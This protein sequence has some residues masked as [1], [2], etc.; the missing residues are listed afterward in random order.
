VLVGAGVLE[1]PDAAAEQR[2]HQVDVHLVDQP[3]GQ[4]LAAR[5][6]AH[7][8]HIAV[9]GGRRR[10]PQRRFRPSVM[11]AKVP[12]FT[13]S[14][15]SSLSSGPA[16]NPSMDMLTSI[17]TFPIGRLLPVQPH[18]A[19]VTPAQPAGT[20]AMNSLLNLFTNAPMPD[21]RSVG[22][23]CSIH[24]STGWAC[25]PLVARRSPLAA[26]RSLLP[27]CRSPLA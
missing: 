4:A 11:N 15:T 13:P 10:P 19:P 6:T 1:Q 20:A 25:P 8:Q 3:G 16:M 9:A 26:C 24:G 23:P 21:R 17:T 2:R 7:D 18:A 5:V 22:S 14:V 27:A 12:P